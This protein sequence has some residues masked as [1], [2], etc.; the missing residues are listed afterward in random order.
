VLIGSPIPSSSN[1]YKALTTDPRIHSVI[2][3]DI[4][5]DLTS[6]PSSDLQ[7]LRAGLQNRDPDNKGVGPHFDLARPDDPSTPAIDE[8]KQTDEAIRRLAKTLKLKGVE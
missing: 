5:G 2:R 4:P 3:Y 6:N 8:G 1:L 7:F